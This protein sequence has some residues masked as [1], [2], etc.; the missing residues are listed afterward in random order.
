MFLAA[1][2]A[3][4]SEKHGGGWVG[5]V[6]AAALLFALE[7]LRGVGL[8]FLGASGCLFFTVVGGVENICESGRVTAS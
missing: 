3:F 4:G 5:D 7:T 6:D 8:D 1:P 2:D